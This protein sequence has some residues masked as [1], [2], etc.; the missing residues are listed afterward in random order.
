M[1][2]VEGA[3]CNFNGCSGEKGDLR[4]DLRGN[5]GDGLKRILKKV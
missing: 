3:F 5:F 4:E 1:S 2:D